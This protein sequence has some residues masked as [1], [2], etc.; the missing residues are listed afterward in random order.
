MLWGRWLNAMEKGG[1]MLWRKVAQCY[2][3]RWLNAMEKRWL[4]AMEKRDSKRWLNT[5]EKGGS[6]VAQLKYKAGRIQLLPRPRRTLPI[7]EAEAEASCHVGWHSTA[8]QS[9]RRGRGQQKTFKS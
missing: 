8:G 7:A 3:E 1:S 4:D 5:I 2:G 9:L 6:M